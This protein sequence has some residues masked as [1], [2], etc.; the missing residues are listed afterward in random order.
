MEK[1][2][3]DIVQKIKDNGYFINASKVIP[4]PGENLLVRIINESS[5]PHNFYAEMHKGLA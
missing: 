1:K 2:K 5:W 4:Y 3:K